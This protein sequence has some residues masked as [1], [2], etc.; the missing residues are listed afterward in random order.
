MSMRKLF[1]NRVATSHRY[2]LL[3]FSPELHPLLC[4]RVKII[5]RNGQAKRYRKISSVMRFPIMGG[6]AYFPRCNILGLLPPDYTGV[7]GIYG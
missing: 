7:G 1:L 5:H 3:N 4:S 2:R 6:S